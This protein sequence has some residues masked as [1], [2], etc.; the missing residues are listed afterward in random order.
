[1]PVGQGVVHK[2]VA[3]TVVNLCLEL[4][5]CETLAYLRIVTPVL[6]CDTLV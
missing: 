3:I 5:G 2:D 6:W 1:M 4:R